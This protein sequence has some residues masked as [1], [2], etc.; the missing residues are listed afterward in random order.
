MAKVVIN[1]HGTKLYYDDNGDI[2]RDDG[3]AVICV[4][5]DRQ[6]WTHGCY[7]NSYVLD[8]PD[9]LISGE[10]RWFGSNELLTSVNRPASD[11]P[12]GRKRWENEGVVIWP[13]VI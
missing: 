8:I 10:A 5:G 4:N 9:M 2:H 13:T 6:Y 7:A 3:A 1:K 12:N 11:S